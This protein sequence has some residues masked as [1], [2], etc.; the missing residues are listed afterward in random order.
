MI[1]LGGLVAGCWWSEVLEGLVSTSKWPRNEA[2]F[3]ASS[4][5]RPR[6]NDFENLGPRLV[7]VKRP[8]VDRGPNAQLNRDQLLL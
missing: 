6:K 5:P 7:L 4:R 1:R 8:R 2:K 3:L